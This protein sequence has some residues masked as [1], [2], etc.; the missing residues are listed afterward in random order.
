MVKKITA[1]KITQLDTVRHIFLNHRDCSEAFSDLK[2]EL[3]ILVII[4]AV[5]V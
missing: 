1:L 3:E 2:R 5:I 4:L